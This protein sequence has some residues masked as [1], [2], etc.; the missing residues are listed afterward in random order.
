MP[1]IP[2][3]KQTEA[4]NTALITAIAQVLQSRA[5]TPSMPQNILHVPTPDG[6]SESRI[7]NVYRGKLAPELI[8]EQ[9][10]P[11]TQWNAYPYKQRWL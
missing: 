7:V 2:S 11:W 9:D 10:N 1:D 3:S 8:E 4:A 6:S 5:S